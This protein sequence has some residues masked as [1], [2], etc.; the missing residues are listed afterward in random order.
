MASLPPLNTIS[1][2]PI[3]DTTCARS[4]SVVEVA[5]E[6]RLQKK[7]G[8]IQINTVFCKGKVLVRYLLG[9]GVGVEIDTGGCMETLTH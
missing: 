2:A 8:K 1:P 6:W 3:V 5:E 7:S 4:K 9:R